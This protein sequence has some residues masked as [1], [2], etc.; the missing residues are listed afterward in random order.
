MVPSGMPAE[1]LQPV[2]G[3]LDIRVRQPGLLHLF[4]NQETLS[5]STLLLW[6]RSPGAGNPTNP[7]SL[8]KSCRI[9]ISAWF[10]NGSLNERGHVSRLRAFACP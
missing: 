10:G 6:R 7:F 2:V 9:R 8:R 4:A 3:K 1:C 5:L